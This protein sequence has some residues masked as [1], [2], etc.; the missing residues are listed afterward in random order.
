MNQA[1][2]LELEFVKSIPSKLEEQTLYVSM[3]YATVVHKCCCGC[4]KEVVT[5]LSPTDWKLTFN[6]ETISLSPSIGNWSFECKSHY[7]IVQNTVN[8]ADRWSKEQ[9][10]SGRNHDRHAKNKHYAADDAMNAKMTA[11]G[12]AREGF[13]ARLLKWLSS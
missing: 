7:W 6:G 2:V 11:P 3:D 9:I 12:K 1:K 4:G 13:W 5:P 10:E 8:W